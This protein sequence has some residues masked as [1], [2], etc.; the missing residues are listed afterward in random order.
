M[1]ADI[2]GMFL[3]VEVK[4]EDRIFLLFL[5]LDENDQF[6]THQYSRHIFGVKSSPTCANFA[7]QRCALDN[8]PVFERSSQIASH[9]FYLTDLL[10]SLNSEKNSSRYQTGV[11][12]VSAKGGFKLTKWAK[13]FD[14]N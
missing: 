8:A 1:K 13:N 12:R 14:R 7:L 6:V 3:Q 2:E 11:N 4:P 9:Y 5:C 10:A